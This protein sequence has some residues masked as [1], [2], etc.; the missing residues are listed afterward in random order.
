MKYILA[1]NPEDEVEVVKT[2][3][4]EQGKPLFMQKEQL[5]VNKTMPKFI[6][7]E[8]LENEKITNNFASW[9]FDV[10]GVDNPYSRGKK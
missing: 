1:I 3:Y 10:C 7:D 9:L 8:M 6:L 5:V 2:D 4:V